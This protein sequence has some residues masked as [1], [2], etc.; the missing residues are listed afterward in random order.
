MNRSETETALADARRDVAN[1]KARI[2][3]TTDRRELR[4]LRSGLI[5]VQDLVTRLEMRLEKMDSAK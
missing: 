2:A 5:F 3:A 4:T 1:K